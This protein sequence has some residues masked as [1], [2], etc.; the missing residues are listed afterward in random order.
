MNLVERVEITNATLAQFVGQPFAFG[1]CDCGLM[2]IRHL[3]AM[4]WT[5]R[6]GGTW[7]TATALKRF[8][9]RHGGSGAACIDSWGLPR[10]AP[11]AAIVG[12]IVEIQGVPPFGAFGICVGNGRIMAFHEDAEGVAILQPVEPPIAAWR[13]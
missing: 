10:I 1:A 5:I 12:D 4:G 7:K 13:A 6:T 2:V 8:L 11:A 3:K 9:K